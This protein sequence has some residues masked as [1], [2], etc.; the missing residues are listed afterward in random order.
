M[1]KFTY[2]QII[3]DGGRKRKVLL[4]G[5]CTIEAVTGGGSEKIGFD[6]YLFES[7]VHSP[8]PTIDIDD[9]DAVVV[10]P[11]LRHF[12]QQA[13]FPREGVGSSDLA[14]TRL[15][16]ED[17]AERY[18]KNCGDVIA[19]VMDKFMEIAKKRPVLFLSMVEP[20][21][22]YLGDLIDPYSLMNP[23]SI[24]RGLNKYVSD[25]A[26]SRSGYY[27]LDIND[28]LSAKGR[29]NIHD[30]YT[31]HMSH[32]SYMYVGTDA[33]DKGRVQGVMCRSDLYDVKRGLEETIPAL[34]ER[35]SDALDIIEHKDQ[36]KIIIVDLDD[37]LWRGVAADDDKPGHEFSEGWPLGFAEAL[38]VYKKRGGLLAVCSKNDENLIKEKFNHWVGGG[39]GIVLS[40]FASIKINFDPK[41]KNISEILS[42]VNLLPENALFIDDNP[43]EI[44][45]V[46]SVFPTMRML[47]K[48]YLGWRELILS[49]PATQVAYI[50]RESENRTEKIHAKI[51]R[52]AEERTMSRDDW[53]RA[54]ELRCETAKIDS[55]DHPNFSRAFE[56]LN[57]TNQFNTTGKRWSIGEIQELFAQGGSMIALFVQDKHVDNGL[58][59]LALIRGDEYVQAVLSCRVFNLGVELYLGFVVLTE[60]MA[61]N[62]RIHAEHIDTGRNKSSSDYFDRLGFENKNGYYETASVPEVPAWINAD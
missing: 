47:S 41:S 46:R 10:Q 12:F 9:Y 34:G 50:T 6:H 19:I 57:K 27:Y 58:V 15:N 60:L 22:N 62:R 5:T 23:A 36:I 29:E 21:R 55:T 61:Q 52:D 2:E 20:H 13:A 45:E 32:A 7:F 38:L 54:L 40:D 30:G 37:T 42:E 31:S 26:H 18:I 11:T 24:V 3:C 1:T 4:L 49:S 28:I 16:T 59:G 44:D 56:L 25:E 51:Q 43:R 53:L 8:L 35:I 17:E 14:W 33:W 48:G 39:G